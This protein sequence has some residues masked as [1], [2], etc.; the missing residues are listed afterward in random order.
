MQCRICLEGP[1]GHSNPLRLR[2]LCKTDAFHDGCLIKWLL[3]KYKDDM[4]ENKDY[5]IIPRCEICKSLFNGVVIKTKII[6]IRPAIYC[7]RIVGF[8]HWTLVMLF[9]HFIHPYEPLHCSEK[10]H[11]IYFEI[12]CQHVSF[13]IELFFRSIHIMLAYKWACTCYNNQLRKIP[14]NWVIQLRTRRVILSPAFLNKENTPMD[15]SSYKSFF[16]MIYRLN[17]HIMFRLENIHNL[18][19]IDNL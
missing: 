17:R 9:L 15:Y 7:A 10:K 19:R 12:M 11:F 13:L 8:I 5:D 1:D 18:P 2:C 3:H 6:L 4:S 14:R 16:Y